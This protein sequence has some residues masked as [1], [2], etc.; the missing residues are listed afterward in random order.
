MAS[1]AAFSRLAPEGEAL[2]RTEPPSGET[3]GHRCVDSPVP[4]LVRGCSCPPAAGI[5]PR[6]AKNPIP[7]MLL[8]SRLQLAPIGV[9][10][11]VEPRFIDSPPWTEIFF[12]LSAC[13]KAYP[14]PIGR[15][16]RIT[17]IFRTRQ[18]RCLSLVEQSR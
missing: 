10:P 1:M 4:N 11:A 17:A 9:A 8:P 16:K 3:C 2:N 13:E 14:I 18:Q 12:K 5:R 15:E 7:A 6:G